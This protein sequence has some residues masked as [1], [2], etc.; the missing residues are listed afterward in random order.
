MPEKAGPLSGTLV[1]DV[2]AGLAG[3]YG[4]FLLSSMG[5]RVIKI[6]MPG[7][8]DVIPLN[9]NTPPFL[10]RDGLS[11]QRKHDDDISLPSYQR[12]RGIESITLDLKRPE[13]LKI[14]MDLVQ[15]AEILF[16]NRARG[17]MSRLGAGYDDVKTVNPSIVYTSISGTGQDDKSGSGKTIDTVAQALSGLMMTSGSADE[18]PVRNGLPL[19]DLMTPVYAVVGT[20]AALAEARKT[21]R[22]QHVDT[23]MLGSLTTLLANDHYPELEDMGFQTRT[24]TTVPRIAPLGI[25]PTSDGY[26]ALCPVGDVRFKAFCQCM[27]MPE[28]AEDERFAQR[29][30]RAINAQALKDIVTGWTQRHTAAQV[31]EKLDK[32]G[33]PAGEVRSTRDALADPRG[34]ARG[35]VV[36]LKHPVYGA[37]HTAYGPGNASKF[38][39]H[40]F[41]QD[42]KVP[43]L[44]EQNKEVYEDLLGYAPD[45]IA[46]LKSTGVI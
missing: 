35:D 43:D 7:P 10:G 39:E 12:L 27:D 42:M 41:P 8:D 30:H 9:R 2:T 15:K 40:P 24:G 4:T 22:G 21:G 29:Y 44:G 31:T 46:Q 18:P 26:V 37:T 36:Q 3:P 13:G 5:A 17:A 33:I 38:S 23:S 16:E 32:V 20:L 1:L 19:A 28:L 11:M 25:Y 14:F 45:L 34:L 6:E